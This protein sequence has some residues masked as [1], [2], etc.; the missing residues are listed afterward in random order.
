MLTV[1]RVQSASDWPYARSRNPCDPRRRLGCR[2]RFDRSARSSRRWPDRRLVQRGWLWLK[3]SYS[4]R[5]SDRDVRKIRDDVLPRDHA[6]RLAGVGY[7]DG[8][9]GQ[10]QQLVCAVDLFGLLQGREG[11]TH[12][13]AHFL[14]QDILSLI[15]I[16]E[17]TRQAE[18]SYA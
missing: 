7:D 13:F 1:L 18:I 2:L 5:R 15:H 16:S 17:P 11:A 14:V 10:G 8:G 4:D 12:H 9:V 6:D 3:I